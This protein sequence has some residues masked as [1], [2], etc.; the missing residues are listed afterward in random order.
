V[1]GVNA[2]DEPKPDVADFAKENKLKQRILLDGSAAGSR[3]KIMGVPTVFW[4]NPEGEIV[5][6]E[7]G[8][9]SPESLAEKT[10]RLLAM[11]Q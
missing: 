4:I 8:F 10:R 7:V 11:K 2:W 1:L 9:D 5:D 6:A 3:Y